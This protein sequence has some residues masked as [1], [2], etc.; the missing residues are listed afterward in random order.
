MCT[1]RQTLGKWRMRV[2]VMCKEKVLFQS[3]K[4]WFANC[5]KTESVI[6]NDWTKCFEVD[7]WRWEPEV[8]STPAATGLLLKVDQTFALKQQAV[9]YHILICDFHFPTRSCRTWKLQNKETI[10]NYRLVALTLALKGSLQPGGDWHSGGHRTL[11]VPAVC[12]FLKLDFQF[13]LLN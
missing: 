4:I 9:F 11:H 7:C 10:L 3:I 6:W 1:T 8:Q 13:G 5:F 2:P 12:S